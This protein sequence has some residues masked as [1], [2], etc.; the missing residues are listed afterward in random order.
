MS[1][2][3]LLKK[4]LSQKR[5]VEAAGGEDTAAG[6]KVA[7]RYSWDAALARA[8]GEKVFGRPEVVTEIRQKRAA[9]EKEKRGEVGAA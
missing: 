4:A 3:A 6:K 9:Y 7:E 2:E 8:G 1:K 5:E